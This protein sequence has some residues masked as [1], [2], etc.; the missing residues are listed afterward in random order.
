MTP[1]S[2]TSIGASPAV[3]IHTITQKPVVR[4]KK[5]FAAAVMP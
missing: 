1:D 5:V 2:Q 4:E 3:E